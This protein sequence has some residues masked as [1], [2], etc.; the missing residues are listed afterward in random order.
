MGYICWILF[1]LGH[2]VEVKDVTEEKRMQTYMTLFRLLESIRLHYVKY[3]KRSITLWY[4]PWWNSTGL[5]GGGGEGFLKE[6]R[7]F[8]NLWK[9]CFPLLLFRWSHIFQGLTLP[10]PCISWPRGP[11]C[12][13]AQRAFWVSH[14]QGILCLFFSFSSLCPPIRFH[15]W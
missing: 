12:C 1:H 11:T 10:F 7:V 13:P 6:L 15:L 14:F 8:W 3:Q 9:V 5:G 2:F 4:L